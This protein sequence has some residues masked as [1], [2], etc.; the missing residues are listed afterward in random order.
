MHSSR[1]AAWP[2]LAVAVAVYGGFLLVT[3][4]HAALPWWLLAM[5]GGYLSA[6]QASL[7]HETVHGH[8]FRRRWANRL[9]GMPG[10]LLWLPWGVY[11]DTHLRHH[12]DSRL[13]DPLEDPE[14][15]Y[16]TPAAW[17]RM[18][19]LGR[20]WLWAQNT[21]AGRLLLGPLRTVPRFLAGE[22]RTLAT[23]DRRQIGHWLWHLPGLLLVAGWAFWVCG[24]PVWLY[25]LTFVY[26]GTALML[27][28]SFLE[29]QAAEAVG[30]RTAVVEAGPVMSLL[31]L[32]NNLHAVHHAAPALPWYALP[33]A[34]RAHRGEVLAGNGAYRYPSYLGLARAY[35]F[36]AKEPPVHPLS[37]GP[38]LQ[39]PSRPAADALSLAAEAGQPPR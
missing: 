23:G 24:V 33:R 10:F 25:L 21:L 31:Y 19:R 6:W 1:P 17:A 38:R 28:R 8:P 32:N 5:L 18:T 37:G 27:L 22:A 34:Y 13:T 11:R 29:H 15:F 39:T 36:K 16:V 3:W 35:L 30:H 2:T 12:V 14:S 9:L 4:F 20:G 26:P 7:Q